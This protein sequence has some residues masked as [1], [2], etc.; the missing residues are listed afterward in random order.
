MWILGLS[1]YGGCHPIWKGGTLDITGG[2]D[3]LALRCSLQ[4]TSVLLYSTELISGGGKRSARG[5]S[6]SVSSEACP[7]T[8]TPGRLSHK[9]SETSQVLCLNSYDISADRMTG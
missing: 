2:V 3:R 4:C 1:L 7:R 8:F 5:K 6:A 9:L